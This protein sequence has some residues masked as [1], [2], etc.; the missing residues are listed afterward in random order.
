VSATS[1]RIDLYFGPYWRTSDRLRIV[2]A[3]IVRL[4]E[5]IKVACR[6]QF[7]VNHPEFDYPGTDIMA[8]TGRVPLHFGR[9][10]PGVTP[11]ILEGLHLVTP[12]IS[13]WKDGT[14]G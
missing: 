11:N 7:P 3:E 2:G 12:N 14:R 5:M 10:A 1:S 8:F 4:G 6:E 13:F 9:I